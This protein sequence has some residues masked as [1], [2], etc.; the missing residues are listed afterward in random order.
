MVAST[1]HVQHRAVAVLAAA[2]VAS[3]AL[4][5]PARAADTSAAAQLGRFAAQAGA[6]G[7]PARGAAFFTTTHGREWSCASCHGQRPTAPGRHA[8]TGKAID[9]LAPT[10]NLAAFTVTARVDKWL[11]RNCND[12]LARE[13]TAG[14]KADVIAWLLTLKP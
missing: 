1:S 5:L 8:S 12:V 6:P 3:L 4:T 9:A 7:D 13:C 11:R 2:L 10:A 14:E